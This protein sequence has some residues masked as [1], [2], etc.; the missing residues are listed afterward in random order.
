METK[1]EI[2]SMKG[3]LGT[4]V[5]TVK[6]DTLHVVCFTISAVSVYISDNVCFYEIKDEEDNRYNLMNCFGTK[7]ELME[8]LEES[9]EDE[10][11]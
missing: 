7:A 3:L 9:D 5:Y 1:E 11:R 8:H 4:K 2:K 10:E 6:T